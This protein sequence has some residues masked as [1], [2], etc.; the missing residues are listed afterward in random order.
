MILAALLGFS[1]ATFTNAATHPQVASGSTQNGFPELS[2]AADRARTENRDD[3]AI[4]LYRQALALRPEWEEGLW[5]LG[6][7][8]YEHE[9]YDD[10]RDL[11]RR[12][13]ALRPD[14]GPGWALLGMSEFQTREY[15]RALEHL[16]Q[17]MLRGMGDRDQMVHSVFYFAAVLLNRLGHYD[18]S[19]G[20]LLRMI[21]SDQ[22][23]ALLIEPAGL[24]ALRIP[25][26][27]A[28][29]PADRRNMVRMA[30]EA[31]VAMQTGHYE[32][33]EAR[34]KELE[35]AYPK[36]PGVHFVYGA[37]LMP[38]HPLDGLRQMQQELAISPYHVLARIRIAEQY[39]Q[40][41]K[42]DQALPFAQEAVRLDPGRASAHMILGE[43]YVGK[44]NLVDGIKELETAR[45]DDPAETRI[46]WDLLRAFTAA[47]R[48]EDAKR[49][50]QEIQRL[51]QA[52]GNAGNPR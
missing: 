26:L 4:R 17:A 49:E 5:Y 14:A 23:R 33:A 52:S 50:K 39:L 16:Q 12:F 44:G 37:Y 9:R 18:D 6:S 47:G 30:G 46:H 48:A 42:F 8:Q 35:Q 27:P 1:L 51:T 13:V 40:E 10:A 25:L 15:P 7:L 22:D 24:A 43:I 21:S 20:M 28:E 11:L 3:E 45:D 41:Q 34:F 29:I 2:Q 36:E 38:L 19:M 31:V 32:D